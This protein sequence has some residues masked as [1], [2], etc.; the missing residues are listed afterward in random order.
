MKIE[1]NLGGIIMTHK[2]TKKRNRLL[3]LVLAFVL[4]TATAC[5]SKQVDPT[6][7]KP[8]E[9]PSAAPATIL[10]S[11]N[12]VHPVE[13]DHYA[14]DPKSLGFVDN[15]MVV[16]VKEGVEEKE[17]LSWFPDEEATVA[18]RFKVLRQWQIR[19]EPRTYDELITLADKLMEK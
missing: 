9:A 6:P 11:A 8:S 16:I 2:T 10:S 3:S 7:S 14:T 4:L 1:N 5:S 18:G 13:E 17:I 12:T 15:I 19:I